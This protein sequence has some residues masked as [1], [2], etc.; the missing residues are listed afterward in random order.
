MAAVTKPIV[1]VGSIN[2]DLVSTTARI[3]NPGETIESTGFQ[4]HA[5]GKGAN[6][7]VAVARLGYPVA[8]IGHVGDDSFGKDMRTNLER[9]GV[10]V[11]AVVT[12]PGSSGVAVILVTATGENC[13]VITAG[14]NALVT[15]ADIDANLEL[16]RSAGVVLTQ[17]EIP[18]ATVEH[19]A[20]LCKRENVPLILDPAPAA[21]L[22][23]ALLASVEWFTPNE[24]EAAFY[25]GR[26]N[27]ASA[28]DNATSLLGQGIH[29][30]ALK[31]GERGAYL[32]S[33]DGMRAQVSSFAV[34][35][36][37]TTAAGDCFNGAFA[38][39]MMLGKTPEESTRF[40]AAAAALSVTKAGAQPSMPS[41]SEVEHLL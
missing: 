29:N 13:I 6:Q 11:S 31:L 3:P 20:Q 18:M 26:D 21:A 4:I 34:Q 8:M 40:A 19:L 10:D 24:T 33:G 37:D 30:V 16:I 1:V 41:R 17:L 22:S 23:S 38:T 15:P 27:K 5:G 35:A 9:E 32:A 36:V 25:T 28:E 7:A 39:G 14:A 12:T 2:I